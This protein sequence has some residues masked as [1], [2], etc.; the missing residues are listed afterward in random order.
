MKF[1][2]VLCANS[3]CE[4]MLGHFPADNPPSN[5]ELYCDDCKEELEEGN[6]H[7]NGDKAA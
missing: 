7:G 6:E 4:K 3:E 1:G 2:K 5:L